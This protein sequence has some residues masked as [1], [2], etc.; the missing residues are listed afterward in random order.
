MMDVVAELGHLRK[1]AEQDA[2]KRFSRLHRLLKQ[3]GLLALAKERIARNKGAQTP[4]IDGQT[5]A[6]MSNEQ[7]TKLSEELR[8]GMY[9]PKPVRRV[10]IPKRNG[11]LRPL[12]I[13]TSRDKIVQ[14][15]VAVILEAIYEPIFRKCSHGFRTQHSTITALLQVSSAYR[16]GAKWIIEGDIT[17]CFGSI[18]HHIILNC[19]RKHIKDERF[20]DIIRRMLQSG[21]MEAGIFA[22]SYSGTP[23][24][25]IVSPILANIVLHEL[26]VWLETQMGVN[27]P[28]Q[29]QDD[30]K[31]RYNPEYH[32]LQ[33]RI[34]KI[35]LYLDGA[36]PIPK[37]T[38][39]EKL[40]QE[41]KEKLRLRKLQPCYLPRK[42]TY[43]VR[44]ADDFVIVLCNAS[45]TEA[46]QMKAAIT[47]WMQTHLGLSLN[48]DKTHITHWQDKMRF[49]GYELEGRSN[50]NGTGW[51][52]L[53]V[54]KE[55]VR[56][57]VTKIQQV[58]R[59]PQ[60]P[61]YDVFKNINAIARGWTNYYRYAHDS[62][63]VGSKLSMVIYWCMAHY[64][65]KRYRSSIAKIMRD[66][67][68]RDPKTGCLGLYLNIPAKPQAPANRYFVWHKAP[69][70]LWLAA[71]P[72]Y[73]VQDK[74]PY[75][76]TDWAAGRS[77]HK[78]LET[79]AK[80]GLHCENCGVSGVML[81]VHH[82]NRLAKRKRVKK[83]MANI[84]QSGMEQETV[85]L[86]RDCHSSY[87]NA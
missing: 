76:N 66:H 24:G 57:I 17:D 47:L 68:A 86:C 58:T 78:K 71:S 33:S 75:L 46:S 72:A 41:L 55:A 19:L 62:P 83:G 20:I 14:A 21:V 37:K 59:F 25:G 82:P 85:L 52:H 77:Q 70:H 79:K 23:Q 18:P 26:D 48:Q 73:H 3:G 34:G 63:I 67:Y 64:L 50:P 1:L 69:P 10:Y 43:Y 65:G 5:M 29:T 31:S 7:I 13:P 35:K 28:P 40:K 6:D 56:N 42:V 11:K 12:G 32:R 53:A 38:T 60:A 45:K 2:N 44:Y 81:Y 8:A 16:S 36:R 39:R 22:P 9:Q 49:L 51:L 87:H 27:P 74:Q 54:P 30:V 15:G 61:E 4:G 80:A 84:A